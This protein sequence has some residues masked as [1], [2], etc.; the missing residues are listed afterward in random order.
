MTTMSPGSGAPQAGA[1]TASGA[2]PSAPAA[3]VA[4]ARRAALTHE[5]QVAIARHL[6]AQ[7]PQ[8]LM[9]PA[10]VRVDACLCDPA[11]ERG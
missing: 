6:L 4:T 8:A 9:V 3:A 7:A 2:P 10:S 11:R 1:A 5:P